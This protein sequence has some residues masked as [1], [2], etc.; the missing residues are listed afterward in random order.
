MRRGR[1][2]DLQNR[3]IGTIEHACA[4]VE[5]SR[6][7]ALIGAIVLEDLD[8]LIDSRKEQLVPRDPNQIL[9]EIE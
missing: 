9:A 3:D 2:C 4:I 1:Q 8:S 6:P 5:P 7:T